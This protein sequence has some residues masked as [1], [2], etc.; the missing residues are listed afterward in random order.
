M[1]AVTMQAF[2]LALS[3]ACAS[4]QRCGSGGGTPGAF[5]YYVLALSWAPGF[6]DT[7]THPI[8]RE[9][10]RDRHLGFVVHGL[11]PQYENGRSP[12]GCAPA[13]PVA[14]DL[15]NRML[16][17]MPDPGLIQHEWACHGTC[18]GPNAREYF[19][20]VERAFQA[21]RVPDEFR[22]PR[23]SQ[24]VRIR[25]LER[26]FADVNRA[27]PDAFRVVCHSG[28]LMEVR[29]CVAKDLKLR[30]CSPSVRECPANQVTVLPVP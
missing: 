24:G 17:L 29:V 21:V 23:Q 22:A 5:D 26:R 7:T 1:R 9:C 4:A 27:S 3:I 28:E 2:A 15:V 30:P 10:G 14:H 6:C 8:E 11:W 13:S 18:Y 19:A 16:A 20:T 25:D 12:E